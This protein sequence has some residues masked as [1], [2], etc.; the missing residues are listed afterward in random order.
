MNMLEQYTKFYKEVAYQKAAE[1]LTML[2]ESLKFLEYGTAREKYNPAVVFQ[3][4][5][6]VE[7]DLVREIDMADRGF[8]FN[9][10]QQGQ[11]WRDER[12]KYVGKVEDQ[13]DEI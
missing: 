3:P 7:E 4:R 2:N 12:N 8:L 9:W 11:Y 1:D 6:T 13:C 5:D 10:M